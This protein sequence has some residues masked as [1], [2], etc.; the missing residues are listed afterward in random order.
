MIRYTSSGAMRPATQR[1]CSP[2]RWS[3]QMIALRSGRARASSGTQ[4]IICPEND[5]Q[6]TSRAWTPAVASS[7]CV[8]VHT[9]VHHASG[10]CS[11]HPCRA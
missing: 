6:A 5:T 8:E 10:S 2:E 3:A 4:P 1:S 9:A 7:A 11:A